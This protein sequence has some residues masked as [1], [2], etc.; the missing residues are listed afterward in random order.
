MTDEQWTL[1]RSLIGK[2]S[3]D[4]IAERIGISRAGVIRAFRGIPLAFQNRYQ[5]DPGLAK[6]I[7]LYYEKHGIRQTEK[8]FPGHDIRG[9]TCRYKYHKPRQ[10]LWT[11]TEIL[12]AAR[13]AGLVTKD[14]QLMFF[15]RPN[16]YISSITS[17]WQRRF[18]CGSLGVNGMYRLI[19][20]VIVLPTCPYIPRPLG[21]LALWVDIEEHLNPDTP[22][23][24]KEG[25][26]TLADYQRWVFNS[27]DPKSIILKM[28]N[29]RNGL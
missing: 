3:I 4:D 14:K 2:M 25:I 29:E 28:M 22:E 24:I 20:E 16:A 5:R 19:A 12:E 17:L 6:R 11:D 21:D 9:I 13:M 27:K 26:K 1:G 15:K 7:C 23:F 10:L 8:T 18:K